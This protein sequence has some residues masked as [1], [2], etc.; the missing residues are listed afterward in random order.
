MADDN[1]QQRD[2]SSGT[3]GRASGDDGINEAGNKSDRRRIIIASLLTPPAVMTLNARRAHA[4]SGTA[5]SGSG[6]P[7][8]NPQAKKYKK[9]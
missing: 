7:Q 3:P 2:P 8:A 1:T 6:D 4:Q 9:H 5:A